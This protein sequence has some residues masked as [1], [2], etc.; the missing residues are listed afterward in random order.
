[1]FFTTFKLNFLTISPLSNS[2]FSPISPQR[3]YFFKNLPISTKFPHSIP[4]YNLSTAR[5]D[6]PPQ[7]IDDD[8]LKRHCLDRSVSDSKNGML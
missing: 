2:F 1:M 7:N 6:F 3:Q 5:K 4:L 8:E